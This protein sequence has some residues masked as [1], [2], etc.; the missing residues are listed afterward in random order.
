MADGTG[1]EHVQGGSVR[2]DRSLCTGA[3]HA[4]RRP[5]VKPAPGRFLCAVLLA[6]TVATGPRTV[7]GQVDAPSIRTRVEIEGVGGAVRSNVEAILSIR[8]PRQARLP[9][10]E[11]RRLHQ[12]APDEIELAL[13]PFGYYR[14]IIDTQLLTSGSTWTARYVIDPGPVMLVD[15]VSVRLDGDGVQDTVFVRLSRDFPVRSGD[16]LSHD[17]YERGKLAMSQHAA[18]RGYFDA[19]F[20]T[21]EIRIDLDEYSADIVIGYRTGPQYK[22]GTITV[23]QDV[24]DPALL[25]G[26]VDIVAGE[27]FDSR[28]LRVAQDL[29]G[30]GPYF[31]RVETQVYPDQAVNLEVPIDMQLIPAPRQRFEVGAGYG[32]D[33]G[34][35]G[36]LGYVFRR[37]NRPGHY[38]NGD[39]RYSQREASFSARYSVPRPYP[40]TSLYSGY[41]G[42]GLTRPDWS[43]STVGLLGVNMGRSFRAWRGV[44]ALAWEDE[45]YTVADSSGT[46]GL[47]IPSFS[48]SRVRTDN[49]LFPNRASSVRVDVRGASTSLG[50]T[51]SFLTL[52]VQ[53]R[54]VRRPWE[55]WRLLAR[56]EIG[57]TAT[58]DFSK[59]PATHRFVTGGD[60]TVRGF[61]YES[62]GP[63]NAMLRS[64]HDAAYARINR[65]CGH[66]VL[67]GQPVSRGV[68]R[69][70]LLGK[71]DDRPH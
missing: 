59:L 29:L 68:L 26:R 56:G 22:F 12:R 40:S 35:R 44:F 50:S 25:E 53:G 43:R 24:V 32:T 49:A 11:W 20:D 4:S 34:F 47:L 10:G 7:Q 23:N 17:A 46:S 8:R 41:A 21:A 70:D 28:R 1:I 61:R 31:S 5:P 62:L 16:T 65:H 2:N 60:N 58:K 30:E 13:Q 33:T 27:P 19:A 55:K 57:Y 37:L 63:K 3:I 15:R 67:C 6:G 71:S 52:G 64:H 51:T 39:I 66:R 54:V 9:E 38:A 18:D 48:L 14:P 42:Y 45:E 36:N 69:H